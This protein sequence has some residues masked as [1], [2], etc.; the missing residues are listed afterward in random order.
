V[1][2]L[3]QKE[4]IINNILRD[5][6]TGTKDIWSLYLYAMKSPITRQKYLRRLDKFFDFIGIQ[7]LTTEEKGIAFIAKARIDSSQWV[8]Y[9]ILKFM[10]FQ[11]DR[12]Q[13]REITGSTVHNYL[14]SIKLFCEMG[15]ISVPWKKISRGLPRGKNY[16]DDRIPTDKE[17]QD[18]L[19]YPD[20]RLKA[21]ICTMSSSGIRLGAWE[22][23]KWGHIRPIEKD[24]NIVAA[25]IIVYAGEDDE[26]FSFI[27]RESYLL[28]L[29]WI[30][31][32]KNSGETI[33]EESWLMRD[34]W[35]TGA[36]QGGR[37]LVTKPQKLAPAGIKRL[38]ERAIWAQGLRKKLENGK[39][40]HPFQAVHCFRKWFKTRCE[41]AGMKPIN[42]EI[43]L[44]HSV[45]ISS[46]YYRPTE[47][48]LLDD[49]LKVSDLLTFDKQEKT[50]MELQSYKEKDKNDMYVLKGKILEKDQQLND[51]TTQFTELRNVVE[52]MVLKLSETQ[53]QNTR[54]ALAQTMFSS[55]LIKQNQ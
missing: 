35:D 14:K 51:L 1:V 34:L 40:R 50:Q 44:S 29:D 17:I 49:Y 48:N 7:G 31:Y 8:F 41:I 26:Y 11:L 16:A 3:Q 55:G 5:E 39:K 37:G 54:N 21:I 38:I 20:R 13:K 12:V 47:T 53:D 30:N 18:L 32:R 27:S 19:K 52:N 43:L 2:E 42:I 36:V 33:S 10:Q 45:G 23:L 46:S 22:Y 15:D 4:N 9:S 25:K 6:S 24:G 28:L